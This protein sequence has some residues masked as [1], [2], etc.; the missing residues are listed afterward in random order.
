[1][2]LPYMSIKPYVQYGVGIQKH[3]GDRLTGYGQAMF[4]NGGRDGVAFSLG[5]R[6]A[7]GKQSGTINSD[8]AVI[9]NTSAPKENPLQQGIGNYILT[10]TGIKR[11]VTINNSEDLTTVVS[12]PVLIKTSDSKSKKHSKKKTKKQSI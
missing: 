7:I 8:R 9:K 6:Y 1:M 11:T 2:Q 3:Y 12:T 4:R 5:L 10:K